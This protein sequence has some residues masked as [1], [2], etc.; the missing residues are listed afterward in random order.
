MSA[1]LGEPREVVAV[2][3]LRRDAPRD[4][5][6][7]D[8]RQRSR[9]R[10]ACRYDDSDGEVGDVLKAI[11]VVRSVVKAAVHYHSWGVLYGVQAQFGPRYCAT[12]VGIVAPW[13]NASVLEMGFP[14]LAWVTRRMTAKNWPALNVSW[15]PKFG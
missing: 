3:D 4:G 9:T 8:P 12:T 1:A 2:Y 13:V 14:S 6:D 15:A 11:V 5:T 7:F 10:Y